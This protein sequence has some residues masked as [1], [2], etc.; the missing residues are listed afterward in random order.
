M[1]KIFVDK[2][3]QDNILVGDDHIH[4]SVV[5]RA[6]IGDKL[7]LCDGDGYDYHYKII[8]I[9]KRSTHL[10]FTDKTICE[11]EPEIKIDLYVALL[12]SDKLEWVCQKCTELGI[13]AIYP[14]VSEFV[15]VKKESVRQERLNKICKEAAQQCGRGKVP[16]VYAPI[17]FDAMADRIKAYDNV[18]FMYEKGG[19]KFSDGIAKKG[20]STAVI[21][22][23]EGGF[24]DGEAARLISQGVK[25]ISLGKRILRAETACITAV[26]LA[27]YEGGELQ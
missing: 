20:G 6:K 7:T 17:D 14:F 18:L 2:I 19:G 12:K 3:S 11:A 23:S 27:M 8:G 16:L 5:L 25:P 21:I 9:D 26:T 1:R 22:G 4:V 24:G 13:N 10:E 15:Q